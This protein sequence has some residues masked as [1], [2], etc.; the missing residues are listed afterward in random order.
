MIKKSI[1]IK[2][3]NPKQIKITPQIDDS[4]F[5]S[6]SIQDNWMELVM[7][8]EAPHIEDDSKLEQAHAS[9]EQA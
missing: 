9:W 8:H 7:T 6:Q 2:L 4:N 1:S 3:L 5:S